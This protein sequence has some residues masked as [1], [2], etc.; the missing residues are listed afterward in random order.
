[1]RRLTGLAC[2]WLAC[3]RVMSMPIRLVIAERDPAVLRGLARFLSS[4]A[5]FVVVATATDGIK[6]LAAVRAHRPD[7]AVLDS[8]LPGKSGLEVAG[9]IL[10]EGLATRVVLV[11]PTIDDREALEVFRL[12]IHGVLLKEMAPRL[13]V[14]CIRKVP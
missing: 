2:Y 9:E 6:S 4:V 13:L 5:D 12:G 7:I 8:A 1:M 11:T 14:Q 10:R 3:S